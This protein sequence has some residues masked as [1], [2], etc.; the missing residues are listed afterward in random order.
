MIMVLMG[1]SGSGKTTIGHL[2]AQRLAW[3]FVDG[4][5]LHPQANIDKMTQ[6]VPLTD[7]DRWPWLERIRS[8]MREQ[9]REQ[10]NLIVAC[11][12]LKQEY[13]EYLSDGVA[14]TWVYLE[15]SP[16][17]LRE[18]M[19][20]RAG[21]FMKAGMLESQLETLEVPQDALQV[22]VEKD[23]AEVVEQIV[24]QVAP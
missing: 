4:D 15:A 1:V 13:R 22:D 8:V 20:H 24:R 2:L 5:D 18:R 7:E 9:A 19:E 14:I 11:S 21:H 16:E 12:A 10:Q 3:P 23:P 6:G 17:V